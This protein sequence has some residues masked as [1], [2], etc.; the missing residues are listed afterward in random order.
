M[1]EKAPFKKQGGLWHFPPD[2]RRYAGYPEAK[3]PTI[4]WRDVKPWED[5]M[6]VIGTQRGR[7]AAFFLLVSGNGDSYPMFMSDAADM[8]QRAVVTRGTITGRWTIVKKGQ[9]YGIKFLED[10]E[11]GEEALAA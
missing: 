6:L 3:T 7:S 10:I 4:E 11:G 8:M 2:L 1:V 5:T 9:N